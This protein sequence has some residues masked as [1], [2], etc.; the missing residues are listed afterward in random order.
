VT[1]RARH[2]AT[3]TVD[4]AS[5]RAALTG[6]IASLHPIFTRDGDLDP[7]GIASEVEHVLAAGTHT[8]LLTYGDS[9][10]SLLTDAEVGQLLR[11][12]VNAT[13]RRAMVVAAD[14]IWAT[15]AEV[16][17]ARE[18]RELGADVLMVLPPTW[19]GSATADSLLAHY[20]AVAQEIPVM[21]VTA[22]FAGQQALGL[23]VLERLRDAEP[24]FVAAKDDVC[25]EFARRLARICKGDVALFSGG[26]KQNHLD[27]LPYGCD[28]WMSTFIQ[29]F[30][31]ITEVYWAAIQRGDIATAAAVIERLDR[32]FFDICLANTQGGFD[33]V[34]HA[35]LELGG[36]A[37][38]WRRAPYHDLD[39]AALERLRGAFLD[40]GLLPGPR[41]S[42][43]L[44]ELAAPSS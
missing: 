4:R 20:R 25:G 10:H 43:I 31:A 21:A 44:G 2:S 1:D 18:A 22:P 29:F 11:I 26:Q 7:E 9:L 17:F 27:V 14:R 8:V 35:A 12:V 16:A 3:P 32:P 37:P 13:G 42:A 36:V 24:R 40:A 33:A 41:A 6:P 15:P 30:P 19:G 38:R 28:G 5:A 39:D 23:E 34:V